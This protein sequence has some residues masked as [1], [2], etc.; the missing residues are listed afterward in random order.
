MTDRDRARKEIRQREAHIAPFSAEVN[1]ATVLAEQHEAR[2]I[3]HHGCGPANGAVNGLVT[4]TGGPAWNARRKPSHTPMTGVSK[5]RHTTPNRQNPVNDL[6][7][8]RL[9]RVQIPVSRALS[10]PRLRGVRGGI[11]R[12]RPIGWPS[13]G[14]RMILG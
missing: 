2:E 9:T 11:I 13:D 4:D 1:G 3:Q 7:N 8:P 5:R 10:D 14:Y 12:G 6:Q